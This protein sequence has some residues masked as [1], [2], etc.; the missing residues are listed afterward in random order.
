MPKFLIRASYT[1]DGLKGLKKDGAASRQQAIATASK[2]MG[3]NLD[4]VYFSAGEGDMVGIV[5]APSAEEV[6]AI[7]VA[8]NASGLVRTQTTPLLTVAEMDAA[9]GRGTQYRPPGA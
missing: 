5:D 4:A 7:C 3:G 9:L 1:A 8:V 6:T 2:A